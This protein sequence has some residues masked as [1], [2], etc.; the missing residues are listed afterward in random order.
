M[1]EQAI[2]TY[3]ETVK[4][5]YECFESR[6][7]CAA[8]RILTVSQYVKRDVIEHYR[9]PAERV[10]VVGTGRGKIR[11][12]AGAKD[13]DGVTLFVAKDRFHEKGGPLL[14]EGFR[15]AVR[16]DKRLKL[17][18]VAEEQYRRAVESVPGATFK[19]ALP[20]AELEVLF[21][22]ASLFAMPAKYEPWG[23]V[24]IEALACGT[25]V[26]GL[27]R[28]ALPELTLNGEAGFLLNEDTPEAIAVGLLDAF[29]NTDRLAE[30]GRVGAR[31]VLD[32]YNWEAT[33]SR[34]YGTLFGGSNR[35]RAPRS[36][37]QPANAQD[38]SHCPIHKRLSV[39]N[40]NGFSTVIRSKRTSRLGCA[41][42]GE[43]PRSTE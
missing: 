31:H 30:M 17:I 2:V 18:V 41:G 15:L 29:S 1:S 11:P 8:E 27:N 28:N 9:V 12:M 34:I 37:T 40:D 20:W 33:A 10:T 24:Y 36:S 6:A 25:P 7:L 26:L 21:N 16:S 35:P 3:G 23:L 5:R 39:S 32:H 38:P 13:S 19:T 42:T 4:R 14:L 43:L 22:R